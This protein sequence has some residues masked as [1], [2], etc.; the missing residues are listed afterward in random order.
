MSSVIVAN[1]GIFNCNL[2]WYFLAASCT[3]EYVCT[4]V[5][6][7]LY[8]HQM[9]V[10]FF[11]RFVCCGVVQHCV[12]AGLVTLSRQCHIA[13]CLMQ[14]LAKPGS[15]KEVH[16]VLASAS[17]VPEITPMTSPQHKAEPGPLSPRKLETKLPLPP[18]I[19]RTTKDDLSVGQWHAVF[20]V[21]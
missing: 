15:G 14:I 2:L 19:H 8:A 13:V 3:V 5:F 20:A 9:W 7:C 17:H 11:V 10:L 4:L 21:L 6:H 1:F 12:N 16:T 18:K